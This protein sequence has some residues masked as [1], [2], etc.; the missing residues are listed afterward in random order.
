MY[1]LW[2]L[3]VMP[4]LALLYTACVLVRDQRLG[5]EA[6]MATP[7]LSNL[8]SVARCA[9]DYERNRRIKIISMKDVDYLIQDS[10]D[11]IPSPKRPSSL[12]TGSST[13]SP[14]PE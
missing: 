11:I 8:H 10:K 9:F 5:L 7:Q 6:Q 4:A 13:S 2:M 1:L 12:W 14:R 3:F